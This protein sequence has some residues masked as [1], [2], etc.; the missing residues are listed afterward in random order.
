MVRLAEKPNF[1]EASCCNVE[2][3]NGGGGFRF[4][5]L[6]STSATDAVDLS[7]LRPDDDRVTLELRVTDEATG[8]TI[9]VFPMYLG[10]APYDYSHGDMSV[11]A[12][13]GKVTICHKGKNTLGVGFS[14]AGAHIS[15]H[16]DTPGPCG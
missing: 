5:G 10:G 9:G 15:G 16:G 14:A 3:M 2:V 11:G 4:V 8:A 12:F 6:R 13:S 1:R 7:A